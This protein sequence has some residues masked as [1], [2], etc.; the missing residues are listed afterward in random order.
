MGRHHMR[1]EDVTLSILAGGRSTRFRQDKSLLMVEGRP[2]TEWLL[3]QLR[4]PFVDAQI[5]IDFI[6]PQLEIEVA[7]WARVISDLFPDK[8]PLCGIYTALSRSDGDYCFVLAC[9]MPFPCIPLIKEMASRLK[10]QAALVP[11][12][13]NLMQPLFAFYSRE[14]ADYLLSFLSGENLRVCSFVDSIPAEFIEWDDI[15]VHDPFGFSFFNI[16]YPEDMVTYQSI[17]TFMANS[18]KEEGI[19]EKEEWIT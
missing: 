7:P 2:I 1:T 11:R 12:Y 4:P 8:G 18:G 6:Q 16:N 9:D 5:V 15:K 14:L 3:D 17:R 10:G 13:D 19:M